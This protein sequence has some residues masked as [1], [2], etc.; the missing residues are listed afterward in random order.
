M[1]EIQAR[2]GNW[3]HRNGSTVLTW[4]GV[5]G[6]I[7]TAALAVKNSEIAAKNRLYARAEK[8]KALKEEHPDHIMVEPTP[9][10]YVEQKVD[11][12]EGV[13]YATWL[14]KNSELTIPERI[15]AECPAYISS[16]ITGAVTIFCILYANILN[17][18]QIAG[19]TA[20]CLAAERMLMEYRE[21]VQT[22][23]GEEGMEEI[24]GLVRR[25]VSEMLEGKPPWDENQMFYIEG[26]NQF[27]ERTMQEVMEAEYHLNRNF[28]LRGNANLN[29]LYEFLRLPKTDRGEKFGWDEMSGEC[30]YGYRWIDFRHRYFITDDGMTVC[31][32]E[33]P[34]AAHPL[35]EFDEQM[36]KDISEA[37]CRAEAMFQHPVQ[38][39]SKGV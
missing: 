25:E 14:I 16:G 38:T 7:G 15:K 36:E 13:P 24:D 26:Q 27:F 18:R 37:E 33:M 30:F 19:L 11:E 20:T 31:E 4:F 1:T 6:V 17:K 32:I 35:Y 28:I 10:V 29:E 8:M 21:K 9:G 22:V 23:V 39:V 3:F 5:A 2:I 12:I 34:F